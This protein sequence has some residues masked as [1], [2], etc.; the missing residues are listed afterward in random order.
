M[1]QSFKQWMRNEFDNDELRDM[2]NHG[3]AGGLSNI[4]YYSET[5][6]LYE[7]FEE[8]IWNKVAELREALGD[9]T[10]LQTILRMGGAKNVDS[11]ETF[12]N[13]L[14]WFMVERTAREILEEE[15]VV[16]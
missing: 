5:V 3:V 13:L 15:G 8:E 4:I 16:L 14:V 7:K 11:S 1:V 6:P 2:V 10:E 9:K 12:K